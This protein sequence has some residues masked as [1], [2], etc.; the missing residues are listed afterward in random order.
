MFQIRLVA[1]LFAIL[2]LP[3][4]TVGAAD[5]DENGETISSSDELENMAPPPPPIRDTIPI[6]RPPIRFIFNN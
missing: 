6:R 4:C 2:A 3:A 5:S 1:L